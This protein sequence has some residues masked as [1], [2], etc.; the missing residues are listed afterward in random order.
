MK[1]P[2]ADID[3]MMK[4]TITAVP[5]IATADIDTMM[6]MTITVLIIATKVPAADIDTMM[7]MTITAVPIVATADID[8]IMKMNIV[9]PIIATADIAFMHRRIINHGITIRQQIDYHQYLTTSTRI[10]FQAVSTMLLNTD[11]EKQSI[12]LLKLPPSSPKT[13]D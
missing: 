7:K 4:M 3:A 10:G 9:V 11:G 1:V 5:I 8:T 13:S 12:T 2:A 6:K